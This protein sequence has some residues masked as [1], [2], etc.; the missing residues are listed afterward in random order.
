MGTASFFAPYSHRGEQ[1]RRPNASQ[2]SAR[3]RGPLAP[4]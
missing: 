1:P 3:L 2:R 4:A